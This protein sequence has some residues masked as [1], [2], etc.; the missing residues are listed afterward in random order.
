[1]TADEFTEV[2]KA[3]L[4]REPFVPFE[5]E[6]VHG[7]RFTV[8]RPDV[9]AYD[10]GAAGFISPDEEVHFFDYRNTRSLGGAP[11]QSLV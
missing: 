3:L 10:G 5:V 8:D 1:M 9:V 2:L 6:L 11:Q 7:E 4:H